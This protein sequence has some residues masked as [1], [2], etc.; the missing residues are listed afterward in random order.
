MGITTKRCPQCGNDRLALANT[1]NA[2]FCTDC[3]IKIHWTKDEG[4]SDY[5]A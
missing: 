1:A 4:Q 3:N 5:Y 2:K